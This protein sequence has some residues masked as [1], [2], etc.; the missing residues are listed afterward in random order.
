MSVNFIEAAKK[1]HAEYQGR[2]EDMRH[3]ER[4]HPEVGTALEWDKLPGAV[5]KHF[6]DAM[7]AF[8]QTLLPEVRAAAIEGYKAEQAE[9]PV[10]G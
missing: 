3:E 6:A 7:C 10:S 2:T 5:Q 8:L 1:F 4:W 9:A